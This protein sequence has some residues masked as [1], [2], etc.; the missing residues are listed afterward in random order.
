MRLRAGRLPGLVKNLDARDSSIVNDG[1]KGEIQ[2]ALRTG[3][4]MTKGFGKLAEASS[5]FEDVEVV[6]QRLAIA[7]NFEDPATRAS[8]PRRPGTEVE[9]GKMEHES[10]PIPRIY[11]NSVRE[12]PVS[13]SGEKVRVGGIH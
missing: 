1:L 11:R 6:Q 13:L 7:H 4:Q 9:L 8:V 12:M 10:I 2:L 3:L 5:L